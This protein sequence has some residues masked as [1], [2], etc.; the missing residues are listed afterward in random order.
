MTQSGAL[1]LNTFSSFSR[2]KNLLS[3]SSFSGPQKTWQNYY[4][5]DEHEERKKLPRFSR[6]RIYCIVMKWTTCFQK[7]SVCGI[8]RD[9]E[10]S[11]KAEKA[12]PEQKLKVKKRSDLWLGGSRSRERQGK[13]LL[14]L[15][16]FLSMSFDLKK[17]ITIICL[18]SSQQ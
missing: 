15:A 16:R 8:K 9:F 13:E 17:P 7:L 14:M 18:P 10:P 3:A 4:L 6:S 1:L 12:K 5:F 2:C 11:T